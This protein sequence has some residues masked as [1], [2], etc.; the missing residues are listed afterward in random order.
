[1][2]N[3]A[4]NFNLFSYSS[5]AHQERTAAAAAGTCGGSDGAVAFVSLDHEIEWQ[6]NATGLWVK[7]HFM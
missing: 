4:I 3:I 2:E 6:K 5:G 1:M 7:S